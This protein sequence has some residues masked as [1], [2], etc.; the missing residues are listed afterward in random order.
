M[1]PSRVL[2]PN[3]ATADHPMWLKM[4][5]FQVIHLKLLN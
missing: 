5:P 4:Y 3:E 1:R 2:F